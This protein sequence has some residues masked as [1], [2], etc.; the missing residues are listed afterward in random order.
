M[1][2]LDFEV[3]VGCHLGEVDVDP[4]SA[5]RNG[6]ACELNTKTSRL[7]YSMSQ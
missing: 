4:G 1:C 2:F 7:L 3:G 6:L 5:V